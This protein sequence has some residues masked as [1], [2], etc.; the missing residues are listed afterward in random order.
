M[1]KTEYK[2]TRG[3]S[4][5]GDQGCELVANKK[6]VFYLKKI[7]NNKLYDTEKADLIIEY[8]TPIESRLLKGLY[9]RYDAKLY[10]TK[11]GSWF[12]VV[13]TVTPKLEAVNEKEAKEIV[14]LDP[15]L[16]IKLFGEVEE[17]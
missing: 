4:R 5:T 9:S 17:A 14:K 1:K 11:K 8:T 7:I 16:Y 12:R 15:D 10:K 2:Y 13:N 3:L 6:G